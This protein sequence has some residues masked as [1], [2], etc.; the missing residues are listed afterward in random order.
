MRF[1]RRTEQA[2]NIVTV[3]LFRIH[4]AYS[5][6]SQIGTFAKRVFST[7]PSLQH[8]GGPGPQYHA[9]CDSISLDNIEARCILTFFDDIKRLVAR[10]AVAAWPPLPSPSSIASRER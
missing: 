3:S 1:S 10:S 2:P 4:G 6:R 7:P 8:R 9:D 5:S